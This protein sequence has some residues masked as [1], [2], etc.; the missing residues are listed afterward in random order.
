MKKAGQAFA[1]S[2]FAGGGEQPRFRRA[3]SAPAGVAGLMRA[4]IQTAVLGATGYAG[5][6]LAR[7]LSWHPGVGASLLFRR[8]AEGHGTEVVP[9]LNGNSQPLQPFSWEVIEKDEVDVLF[10][11][12]PHDVSRALVPEA[13]ER[14]IRVID[15]SGA[16]RSE[17]RRVGKECRAGWWEEH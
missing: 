5:M 13:V 14:G 10:L 1:G 15:L 3:R 2:Y 12:T 6:E 9:P 11:A 8:E 16:W 4:K 7:L 17:E